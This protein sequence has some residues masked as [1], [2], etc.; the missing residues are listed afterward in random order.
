MFKGGGVQE[1]RGAEKVPICASGNDE[2]FSEQK[3]CFIGRSVAKI[4]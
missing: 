2:R 4:S 1:V 3:S